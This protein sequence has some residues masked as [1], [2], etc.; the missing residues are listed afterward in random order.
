MGT[1]CVVLVVSTAIP[2]SSFAQV[3]RIGGFDFNSK[4]RLEGVYSTNVQRERPETSS[5]SPED[6]YVVAG[7]DLTGSRPV[8]Q[9]TTLDLTTGIAEEHHFKR[10]DLDNS[11]NPLGHFNI[12]SSSG[13]G[14][15]EVHAEGNYDRN[16]QSK[17][18]AYSPDGKGK[19][20]DPQAQ[21]LYGAG[22]NYAVNRLSMGGDYTYSST[23]HDLKEFQPLDDQI[24][25]Y[26]FFVSYKLTERLTPGY[27][28]DW[29]DTKYPNNP[30]NSR[31]QVNQAFMFPFTILHKPNLA[32]TFSWRKQDTGTGAPVRW[33]PAHS[34]SLAD[35]LRLSQSL[36]LAYFASYQNEITMGQKNVN[37]T[38][39]VSLNHEISRTAS[40]T[41]TASRQP[42]NTLGSTL[43]SEITSYRYSFT[44]SD[45][46]IYDL[47]L[48]VGA[49]Y[50]ISI[51]FG[52]K[53]AP[54]RKTL[55]YDAGL[56]YSKAI[57]PRLNRS[58]AY[59]YSYENIDVQ[60]PALIEH[61]VTL[62]YDYTF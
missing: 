15:L 48:S 39:G 58:L 32:Y 11:G 49:G 56:H 13:I 33:E 19:A 44:K 43:K 55:R 61:R 7:L 28:Y 3:L 36:D 45:L 22:A 34:V 12:R 25:R 9:S 6:Y 1:A 16:A 30:E 51:P 24:D 23:T 46:F 27:M 21:I 37:P 17:T 57:T 47:S 31:T 53:T 41:L 4:A 2:F 38:Y 29:S 5:A 8:G 59:D 52:D 40:E 50:E 18:D 20:R 26:N 14:H 35:S 10:S 62:S 42:V 60:P 54:E